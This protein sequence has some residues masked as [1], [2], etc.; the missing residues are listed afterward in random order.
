M[1]ELNQ[2]CGT[3]PSENIYGHRKKIVFFQKSIQALYQSVGRPL[4]ILDFGCG[5]GAL[6]AQ[7]LINCGASEMIYWGVDIHEPSLSYARAHFSAPHVHFVEQVPQDI[8]FDIIIYGDVL[9]HLY[10]P[11]EILR[12]HMKQLS[13]DG[14]ILASIPNGYGGFENERRID[15]WLYLTPIL[16]AVYRAAKRILGL[17]QRP[18]PEIPFNN[19]SGH[20]QFFTGRSLSRMV[21]SVGLTVTRFSHGSF[22]GADLSGS[23]FLRGDILI[24]LNVWLADRFPAW[25]VSTWHFEMRCKGA[26]TEPQDR[27]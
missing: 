12:M 17:P 4:Q 14:V 18:A 13:S 2:A 21:D 6:V 26:V 3:L 9:E 5:S 19:E 23:L 10:E 1:T 8:Q 25:M 11:A 16:R 27:V 7:Y 15:R 20:V 24:R 22:V